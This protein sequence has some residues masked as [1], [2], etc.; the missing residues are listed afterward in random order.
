M[1]NDENMKRMIF[2]GTQCRKRAGKAQLPSVRQSSQREQQHRRILT[3]RAIEPAS[4]CRALGLL[5]VNCR[6]STPWLVVEE[7]RYM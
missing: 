5:R 4:H 2:Y 3:R 1:R 7:I 6:I